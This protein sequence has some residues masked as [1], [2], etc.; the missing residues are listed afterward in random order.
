MKKLTAILFSM[1]LAAFAWAHDDA[2]LDKME[3]PHGGQL[4]MAGPYHYELVVTEGKLALYLSDHAG[5]NISSD[6]VS[7]SALL[8]SSGGKTKIDLQPAGDNLLTGSGEFSFT[9]DLKAVVS[10]TFPDKSVWQAK[11]T[12][13]EK[14]KPSSA[15]NEKR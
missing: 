5:N 3:T 9:Q 8:L 15:T 12:P 10:L 7:G 4:R 11:F 1:S 2:T 13:G 14:Q 6:G